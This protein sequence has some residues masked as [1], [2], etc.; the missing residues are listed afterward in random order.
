MTDD[1]G[2]HAEAPGGD[3][4]ATVLAVDDEDSY[5]R[6][7]ALLL[8]AE[9]YRVLT[10]ANRDEAVARTR[11]E[12]PDLVLLDLNLES[13]GDGLAVCRDLKTDARTS[14]VPVI[15]ITGAAD[16]R[17]RLD[18]LESGADDFLVKPLSPPELLLRVR[19]TLRLRRAEGLHARDELARA[20]GL[21]LEAKNRELEA[22]VA[23]LRRAE[24]ERRAAERQRAQLQTRVRSMAQT[25]MVG[26]VAAGVAHEVR[27]PLHAIMSLTDALCAK[28]G[29]GAEVAPFQAHL[30]AQVERLAALM[31]DLLDFGKPLDQSRLAPVTAAGICDEVEE[32]WRAHPLAA[33]HPLRIEGRRCCE[34]LSVTGDLGKLTQALLNLLENGAQHSPEAAPLTLRLSPHPDDALLVEVLDGGE[35]VPEEVRARIFEPFFTTRRRGTGLG[36]SIVRRIAEDHGG[37]VEVGPNPAGAGTAARLLLPLRA[38]DAP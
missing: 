17:A 36:L 5:L 34:G 38:G 8:G 18:C 33:G 9:G 1:D 10:A 3:E 12:L 30:R 26:K 16:E 6:F 20:H 7:L 14:H 15:A 31:R 29:G 4:R 27:N 11:F 25:E 37:S 23:E 22:T 21:A 28:V 2:T 35:G 24:A 32:H 13:P 19:N